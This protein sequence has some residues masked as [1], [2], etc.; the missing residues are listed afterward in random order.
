MSTSLS[1]K[2][3][4]LAS[5]IVTLALAALTIVAMLRVSGMEAEAAAA[6]SK[7]YQSYLLADELRQSSDDLTRLARTYVVT[8]DL[9]YEQQYMDILDVRNGKKPRASGGTVALATLMKQAGFS[10]QEFGKLKEAE[11]NSND[12]VRTEVIAMNAVKGKFDDGKGAFTRDDTPDPDMARRIMHDAAY[13]KN[14]AKIMLPVN[15]FLVML[16]QRTGTEVQTARAASVSAFWLAGGMLGLLITCTVGCLLIAYRY[17][18]SGLDQAIVSAERIA[19]G[20]LSHEIDTSRNDEI[21]QL[22]QAVGHINRGVADMIGNIRGSTDQMTVATSEIATGNADLSA[23]T[24]SQA[25]S[26]E[27]TASAMETLTET[28]QQNAANASQANHLA[29]EA[30]S[31]AAQGGAVVAQVVSTMASIK[32]SSARITDIISVI[33]GIAFQTNILALNAAVEAARAG[34]QGRGFA[35]VASEV[36]NLAQ[37]SASAAKEIKELIGTSVARVDEGGRLVDAAG[38]T[39]E[40]IV[41]SV[42]RVAHIMGDITQASQEQSHGIGEVNQAIA[43]MDS[44]TQQNAALV[45]EAAAA[46]ESLQEQARGLAQAVSIFRLAGER[47]QAA[48]PAAPAPARQPVR[49]TPPPARKLSLVAQPEDAWA[50]F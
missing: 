29:T 6:S 49:S 46:A 39:M 23:R 30:A 48:R 10:D 34:E 20:D 26:L 47:V 2:K 28:V 33:D 24:E 8:G 35:V 3:I 50:T 31:V 40:R 14:K 43:Q 41:T 7:R 1:I 45:E 17:I 19:E 37:R 16:D 12:L 4:F 21:G 36:R 9:A 5:F 18:R 13:H 11:A 22:L 27:E 32:D 25:S 15:E 38:Q 42:Q 44:I